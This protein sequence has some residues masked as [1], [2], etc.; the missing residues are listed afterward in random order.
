MSLCHELADELFI[1]RLIVEGVEF[2]YDV[3]S[4]DI[5][6]L[7]NKED[8]TWRKIYRLL[9]LRGLYCTKRDPENMKFTFQRCQEFSY[10]EHEIVL[11]AKFPASCEIKLIGEVE[12]ITKKA[13]YKRTCG[14]T[15]FDPSEIREP[16]D[17]DD[18]P[19]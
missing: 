11:S 8:E 13:I 14:D 12:V 18:I 17:S 5:R 19:F 16:Q 7:W 2:D 6:F 9:R 15:S 3:D 4:V 10:S 1:N